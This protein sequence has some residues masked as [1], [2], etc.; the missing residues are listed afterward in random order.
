MFLGTFLTFET[1]LHCFHQIT[2]DCD[3]KVAALAAELIK[4]H[5]G[6][7]DKPT[8]GIAN[9]QHL[10]RVEVLNVIDV[11]SV[12]YPFTPNTQQTAENRRLGKWKTHSPS[13][14]P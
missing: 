12:F 9:S 13:C 5:H 14:Q 2:T 4:P 1:F 10:L 6:I 11:L 7:S 8:L 3:H